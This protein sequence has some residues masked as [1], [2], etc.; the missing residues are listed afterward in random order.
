MEQEIS[1]K[2]QVM[3]GGLFGVLGAVVGGSVGHM[4]NVYFPVK[5]NDEQP[6]GKGDAVD[7]TFSRDHTGNTGDT[8]S[9]MLFT[10]T[11]CPLALP[12]ETE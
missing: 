11:V 12:G 4:F 3:V 10:G 5:P 2:A 8:M 6:Q 1:D 9:T 7:G